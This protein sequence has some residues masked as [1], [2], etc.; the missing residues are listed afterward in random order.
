MS[1][2]AT[3]DVTVRVSVVGGK[4]DKFP[5]FEKITTAAE[6]FY[7][8]N[9]HG[10]QDMRTGFQDLTKDIASVEASLRSVYEGAAKN[11]GFNDISAAVEELAAVQREDLFLDQSDGAAAA[12]VPAPVPGVP[13]PYALAGD[14]SCSVTSATSSICQPPAAF[15]LLVVSSKRITARSLRQ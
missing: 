1:G 7:N 10:I 13:T 15:E 5:E 11:F 2:E 4:I 14:A 9:N 12:A 6:S 8:V 3:R